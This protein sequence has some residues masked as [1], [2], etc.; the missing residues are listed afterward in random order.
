MI[1]LMF[2]TSYESMELEIEK[3]LEA[4]P[5]E[6]KIVY[7]CAL[8][9]CVN[10][11]NYKQEWP[12]DALIARGYSADVI[13]AQNNSFPVIKMNFASNEVINAIKE[14]KDKYHPRKIAVIGHPSLSLAAE[15]IKKISDIPIEIYMLNGP[16]VDIPSVVQTAVHNGC[17]T[18][19]GGGTAYSCAIEKKL[20]AYNVTTEIETLWRAV[21][22]AV[23]VVTLQRQEQAKLQI[24][25]TIMDNSS[26]GFILS[27]IDGKIN[28]SNELAS[29]IFDVDMSKN[30]EY[31]FSSVISELSKCF[32]Q[33]VDTKMPVNNEMLKRKGK[34]YVANLKPIIVDKTVNSVLFAFHD[35][36]NIQEIETEIRNKLFAK[37][38]VANYKFDDIIN[39]NPQMKKIVEIAKKYAAVDS[40]V[41]IEG[42]T[43]TGKELFAQSIHQFSSRANRPF[44]AVN[45]AAIPEHLL[46]SE[47]FGYSAGSFTGASKEGKRGLFEI[48][49]SG[50]LFL[51][52]VS[53]LPLSFQ[54]KL[55]RVLQEREL[56]RI[57]DDKVIPVNIRIIAATNKDLQKM[58][59]ENLFRKDLYFRL[60][61]LEISI[62]P[63]RERKEDILPLFYSFLKK[64]SLKF[65]KPI[66]E[67][68]SSELLF[69]IENGWFG[70]IRELQNIAERFMVLYEENCD[71]MQILESCLSP[72]KKVSLPIQDKVQTL[73]RNEKDQIAFV[74]TTSSSREQAAKAMAISRSTL[75]RKMKQ[76]HLE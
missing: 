22:E 45:C 40:N 51:D 47:L 15:T 20:N 65:S 2:I 63:L 52:E 67:F 66:P 76:Y 13:A 31:Y 14:C 29:K 58:M 35:I 72:S 16:F 55:L 62:P 64:Y 61:I 43:G 21:N 25:Q 27:G 57:G 4:F 7:Q 48:A 23:T 70:N 11:D 1:K 71:A 68:L 69:L 24:L 33:V 53:E 73:H 3:V 8:F 26:Q 74:L 5:S 38:M 50:T 56:R 36:S 42:E 18:I 44:V 49:H 60:D 30:K 46:E 19:I 32:K 54:G 28:S 10:L 59:D 12:C 6:E 75:W 39:N 41:L 9:Y 37:G 34:T 17:D